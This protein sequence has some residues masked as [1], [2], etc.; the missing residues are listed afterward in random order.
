LQVSLAFNKTLLTLP[1]IGALTVIS[2]FIAVN[3]TKTSFSLTSDPGFTLISTTVDL[4]GAPN[5]LGLAG[6]AFSLDL[7]LAAT[8][9]SKISIV[10]KAPLHL[11]ITD[12]IPVSVLV[13]V[14]P[15]NSTSK[16]LPS[17]V[18]TLTFK[19]I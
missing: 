17:V 10:L 9:S 12:Y 5:Y 7:R 14:V 11:N 4:I 1:S 8:F 15:I 3:T 6:S 13:F 19:K 18:G 16:F 2:I